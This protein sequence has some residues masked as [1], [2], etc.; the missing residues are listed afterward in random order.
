MKGKYI[1][2]LSKQVNVRSAV[3]WP[4]THPGGLG[5]ITGQWTWE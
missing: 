2:V 1:F 5:T 3:P 4:T